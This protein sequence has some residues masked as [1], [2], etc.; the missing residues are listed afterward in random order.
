MSTGVERITVNGFSDF[1]ALAEERARTAFGGSA[2]RQHAVT[3][4]LFMRRVNTLMGV[5]AEREMG[6]TWTAFRVGFALWVAGPQE[7]HRVAMMASMS[8]AAV[9]AARKALEALGYVATVS[10]EADLRSVVMSLTPEG[11]S[12]IEGVYR[13]HLELTEEWLSPLS[14]PEKLILMGL[15]GKIMSS[16][17]A[18]EYGPGRVVNT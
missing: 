2:E 5:D 3:I 6:L 11:A 16:P 8:R 13:R 14:D 18:S 4:G 10:S 9:S 1:V 15:L 7:P 12:H 17:R